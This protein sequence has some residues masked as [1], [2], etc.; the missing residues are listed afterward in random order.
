[1]GKG[2]SNLKIK[3]GRG[4]AYLTRF[5]VGYFA[6]VIANVG[7][8]AGPGWVDNFEQAVEIAKKQGRPIF[9]DFSTSWCGVCKQMDRTVLADANI[10]A[11]LDNYVKVK[12]DAE[13]RNDLSNRYAIT[14]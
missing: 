9:A 10:V 8:S 2:S 1:M 13:A 4:F 14:G 3:R 11:R 12:V 6:L 5:G 7:F